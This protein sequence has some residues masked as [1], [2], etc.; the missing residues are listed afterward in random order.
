MK[1]PSRIAELILAADEI[2]LLLR[3]MLLPCIIAGAVDFPG[4]AR[5]LLR[6]YPFY[7]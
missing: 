1:S 3:L 5:A 4:L 2:M 6:G 7:L